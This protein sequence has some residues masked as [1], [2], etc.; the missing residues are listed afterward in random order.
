MIISTHNL[1]ELALQL[2]PVGGMLLLGPMTS[3]F[4]TDVQKVRSGF[5]KRPKTEGKGDPDDRIICSTFT[6]RPP[7]TGTHCCGPT[8]VERGPM[9]RKKNAI[10][11]N[12]YLLDPVLY[13]F[14]S[15]YYK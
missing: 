15:T 7:T 12:D 14:W 3:V 11:F 10:N 13:A 1:W 9:R 4:D 5:D 6:C 8:I 2:A